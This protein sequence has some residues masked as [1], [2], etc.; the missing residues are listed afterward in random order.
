MAYFCVSVKSKKALALFFALIILLVLTVEI[1]S[2]ASVKYPKGASVSDRVDYLK[3]LGCFVDFKTEQAKEI[4]IPK[5]FSD[6]YEEYNGLQLAAGFDLRKYKGCRA[7]VYEYK[8][9]TSEN[10]DCFFAHLIVCSGK[11]IGGDICD[12]SLDGEML[13]LCADFNPSDLIN[14]YNKE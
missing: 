14:I 4:V 9:E 10:S 5:E 3:Q 12:N 2:A 7:T 1:S 8:S 6:V 13:P 11:I